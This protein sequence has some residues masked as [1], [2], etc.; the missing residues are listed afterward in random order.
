MGR[1]SIFTSKGRADLP[2]GFQAGRAKWGASHFTVYYKP[3]MF[4]L[5]FNNNATPSL[6][7]RNEWLRIFVLYDIVGG[8]Y[9]PGF[10]EVVGLP[11]EGNPLQLAVRRAFGDCLPKESALIYGTLRGQNQDHGEVSTWIPRPYTEEPHQLLMVVTN[12]SA[13]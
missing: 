13:L 12:S 2:E 4:D 11:V 7:Y 9:R 10:T 6:A 1:I 5:K 8:G 3:H